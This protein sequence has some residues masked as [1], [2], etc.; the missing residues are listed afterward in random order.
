[1]ALRG[2][3]HVHQHFLAGQAGPLRQSA[4]MGGKGDHRAGDRRG[5]VHNGLAVLPAVAQVINDDG[6]AWC[7]QR[8]GAQQQ[9]REQQSQGQ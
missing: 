3:G 9:P 1:M 2:H 5:Q 8:A 6:N 7:G 4:G